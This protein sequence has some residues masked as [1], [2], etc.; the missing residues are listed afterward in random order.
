M[1]GVG[2]ELQ[3]RLGDEARE[4]VGVLRQDHR[5]AVAVRDEH[6]HVDRVH[7]LKCSVSSG[8]P[9]RRRRRTEP[10]SLPTSFRCHG[11]PSSST[12][13]AKRFLA[14]LSLASDSAKKT[15][16]YPSGLLPARFPTSPMTSGAQPCIPAAPPGRGRR[17]DQ[18]PYHLGGLA[19][20]I[21]CATKLPIENPE[22]IH[23]L[24]AH[25]LKER[26]RAPSHLLNR[27]RRRTRR[28]A[29]ADVVERDDMP[30][31]PMR[32]SGRG[33][34]CRGSPGSA[35]AGSALPHH[36]CLRWCRGRRSRHRGRAEEFIRK[37]RICGGG[38]SCSPVPSLRDVLTSPG[39]AAAR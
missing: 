26:R 36:R 17:E 15:F 24:V 3:F 1:R 34:N 22:Q 16:R 35:A 27:V 4:Q 20:V 25:A 29:H 28:A 2:V 38:R 31:L 19:S 12:F 8:Y 32:R 6:R 11:R 10:P 5:V 21:S 30:K 13:G 14:R 9:N 7:P 18:P 39:R 23:L 33:P 37:T